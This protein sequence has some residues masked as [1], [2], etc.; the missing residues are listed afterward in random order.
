MKK[1]Y[2]LADWLDNK[3]DDQSLKDTD[4]FDTLKKIKYYS[5]QFEKPNF[6]KAEVFEE[7]KDR[8]SNQKKKF[9]WSIAAS[10]LLIVGISSLVF[11]LSVKDFTSQINSQQTVLLPDDS[12]VILAQN[13][14]FQFNN[15]FWNFD[16][17]TK[18]KGQAY[19][20]VAKGK[21]FTVKTNFGKVKVLGT[22][23]DVK[24]RDSI[25]KVICYEG[26]VNVIF[27]N[28][29]NTLQKGQ[30]ITYQNGE[31]IEQSNVYNEKPEWVSKTH[32]FKSVS[33][34]EVMH[35][36]EKDY[37]IEVD[38]SKVTEDKSFTGTLPSDSLSL[39]L[40]ILSKTYQMNFSVTN[41]NKFI[42]V[43][44]VQE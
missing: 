11:I 12:K 30:F 28:E 4:G 42:F 22:R 26:S 43:D 1:K 24:S 8:Q 33:L 16:R 29:K 19:F 41:E 15:W 3:V 10:I 21:T 17:T 9:N 27:K 13:S 31:K 36:L 5:A 23:F 34:T 25:F 39:A 38:I 37:Q 2:N 40:E 44:D 32:Q 7:L 14:K 35:Q 6:K 20:E 18:L